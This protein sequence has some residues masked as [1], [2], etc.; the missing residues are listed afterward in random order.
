MF[1]QIVLFIVKFKETV[2]LAI[3][4]KDKGYYKQ[5]TQREMA[6]GMNIVEV[7]LKLT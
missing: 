5:F 7:I 4:S 3:M 2:K 1:E 6:V